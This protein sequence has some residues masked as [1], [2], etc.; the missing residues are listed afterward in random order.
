MCSKVI[1]DTFKSD[2]PISELGVLPKEEQLLWMLADLVKSFVIVGPLTAEGGGEGDSAHLI[3]DIGKDLHHFVQDYR[4][5]SGAGD[6]LKHSVVAVT[7]W[8]LYLP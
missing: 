8:P 5:K 2:F 1:A 7:I 3:S 4:W 6:Q